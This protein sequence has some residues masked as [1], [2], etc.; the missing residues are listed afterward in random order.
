MLQGVIN[1]PNSDSYLD[2]D[3]NGNPIEDLSSN[4]SGMVGKREKPDMLIFAGGA[5]CM[6]GV[7]KVGLHCS[8]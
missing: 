4:P 3:W 6:V 2:F 5:I 7:D 1:N 8:V